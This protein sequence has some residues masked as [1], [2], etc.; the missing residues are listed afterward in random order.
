MARWINIASL[1]FENEHY[2]GK[3]G[4][5]ETVLAELRE[6][7]QRLAGTGLD[8]LATSEGVEAIGMSMDE[9]ESIDQPGDFLKLYMDFARREKCHVAGSL[10]LKEKGKIYNAIVFI[11]DC[12][13]PVGN[14]RKTFLTS[15]EL[16]LS[17]TPGKGAAVFDTKIGRLG[18]LICFDLNFRELRD[19]YAKLKPDILVFASMYHGGYVQALWAHECRSFFVSALQYPGGGILDPLGTPLSVTDCYNKV[20]RSEINLDRAVVHLDFNRDKFGDIERK[21][22]KEV[23]IQTPPNLGP[24]IIYSNSEKRSAYDIVREFGLELL[25]DYFARMRSTNE[26]YRLRP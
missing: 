20:A 18:G 5:R 19:E 10:K 2:R 8:L 24:A 15:T 22:G 17:L 7:M 13:I 9:A 1:L 14:Y 21:Y 6:K 12:G 25:D 11:D 26:K 16:D 23:R 3:T 4:A